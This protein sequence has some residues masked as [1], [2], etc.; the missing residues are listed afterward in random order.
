MDNEPGTCEELIETTIDHKGQESAHSTRLRHIHIYT[1]NTVACCKL[2]VDVR[3]YF[4][5]WEFVFP[6]IPG[7]FC[8]ITSQ[9]LHYDSI[10]VTACLLLLSVAVLVLFLFI[11]CLPSNSVVT[12]VHSKW[13]LATPFPP[14]PL[15]THSLFHCFIELAHTLCIFLFCFTRKSERKIHDMEHNPQLKD[16]AARL[17]CEIAYWR[18]QNCQRHGHRPQ[19]LVGGEGTSQLC[20][21]RLSANCWRLIGARDGFSLRT[22]TLTVFFL[23]SENDAAETQVRFVCPH[24]GW[25]LLCI[26]VILYSIDFEFS[27]IL[28]CVWY[29]A[30]VVGK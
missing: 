30:R 23:I 29:S 27:A 20:F 17:H 6:E 1:V 18:Q 21:H 28:L 7:G 19:C 10:D 22:F 16:A 11:L 25:E 26:L 12:L 4:C 14:P 8:A 24:L 5:C 9:T 2:S 3:C 15:I 13:P